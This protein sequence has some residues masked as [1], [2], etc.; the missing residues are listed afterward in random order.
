MFIC[1][2]IIVKTICEEKINIFKIMHLHAFFANLLAHQNRKSYSI[3]LS[4]NVTYITELAARNHLNRSR[5]N[6]VGTAAKLYKY[7]AIFFIRIVGDW[8]KYYHSDLVTTIMVNE[9]RLLANCAS[10]LKGSDAT[11]KFFIYSR[12]T[13]VSSTCLRSHHMVSKKNV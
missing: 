10:L 5:H 3:F 12:T 1:L 2:Y 9:K 4:M 13:I 11:V 7:T 6:I 8:Q